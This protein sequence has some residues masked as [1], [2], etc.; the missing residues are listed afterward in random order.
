M[1]ILTDTLPDCVEIDGRQYDIHCD[2][3]TG[4][5]I[6][7]DFE[8]ARWTRDEKVWLM[9]HRLY[10][11]NVPENTAEAI[12]LALVFLN[13]GEESDRDRAHDEPKRLYSFQKDAGMIFA[14]FK[15]THGIDLN[16]DSIHWWEFITLFGSMSGDTAFSNLVA[17]RERVR[18]GKATKD[19]L[20]AARKMGDAFDVEEPEYMTE[21]EERN[22]DEFMRLW[23]GV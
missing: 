6:M 10:G 14:A 13:C 19:E 9:L 4:V 22:S 1:N 23:N 3:R 16:K 11:D 15:Q 18:S 20:E 5:R 8:S 12:R 21:E 2:F 17:L 7:L